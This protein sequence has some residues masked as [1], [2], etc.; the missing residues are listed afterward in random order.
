MLSTQGMLVY[1]SPSTGKE[2]PG[3]SGPPSGSVGRPAQS[4]RAAGKQA[5]HSKQE[6]RGQSLLTARG[7][8]ISQCGEAWRPAM[9]RDKGNRS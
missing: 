5:I 7:I 6:L 1:F 9:G 4:L 2:L 8:P 3:V